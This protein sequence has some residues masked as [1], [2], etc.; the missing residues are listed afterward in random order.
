MASKEGG[1]MKCSGQR[2]GAFWGD[3]KKKGRWGEHVWNLQESTMTG[4]AKYWR[5]PRT[6]PR[7]GIQPETTLSH[8]HKNLT[9]NLKLTFN[10]NFYWNFLRLVTCP[11]CPH[12]AKAGS[13]SKCICQ[14]PTKP[15][16]QLF[17]SQGIEIREIQ[18]RDVGTTEKL[19]FT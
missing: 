17:L 1:L 2:W 10:Q 15:C 3:C 16:I 11:P 13:D 19:G 8:T 7:A 5:M 14:R 9:L 4:N 12:P 18:E 6:F